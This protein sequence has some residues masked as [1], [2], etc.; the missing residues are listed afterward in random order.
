MPSAY[1]KGVR[2]PSSCHP[3]RPAYRAGLCA[4]C[5]WQDYRA[6]RVKKAIKGE[7]ILK[8]ADIQLAPKKEGVLSTDDLVRIVGDYADIP[9]KQARKVVEAILSSMKAELKQDKPVVIR[10]FG[11]LKPH[12]MPARRARNW[13]MS[14]TIRARRRVRFIQHKYMDYLLNPHRYEDE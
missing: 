8:P 11:T 10:G 12:R 4:S 9:Y 7:R 14:Y 2:V 1:E 5:W 6:N 3:D 13:H